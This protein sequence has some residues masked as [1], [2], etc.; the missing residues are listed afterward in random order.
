MNKAITLILLCIIISFGTASA[1]FFKYTDPDG[2]VHYT[3][4]LSKVPESQRPN[5]KSYEESES[6]TQPAV[7]S[8]KK[9]PN[10]PAAEASPKQ[11]GQL[12]EERKQINQKQEALSKEY[13]ALMEEKE[14][15]SKEAKQ[16]KNINESV[17]LDRRIDKLN[18]KIE[19]Y[20]QKR[21]ALDSEIEAYNS[22]M[23]KKEEADKQ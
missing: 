11:S 8:D 16:K 7:S 2:S 6:G 10:Q 5:V 4:D 19:Q 12:D 21:K 18:E 20:D 3:D 9:E 14:R 1:E 22:K 13:K 17:E 23:S 15:L